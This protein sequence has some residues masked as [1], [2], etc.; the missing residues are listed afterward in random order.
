[1]TKNRNILMICALA[2]TFIISSVTTA[3][4]DK[5]KL[6]IASG[7]PTGVVYAGLMQSYFQPML[8]ERVAER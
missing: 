7:H 5:I 8:A 6:R 4:A 3:S 1:M 2:L